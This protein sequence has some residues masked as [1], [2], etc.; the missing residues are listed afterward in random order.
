V[1][2]RGESGASAGELRSFLRERLPDYMTPSAFVLVDEFPQTPN[3][4]I[5]HKALPAPE[6][7]R[8]EAAAPFLAPGTPMEQKVAAIWREVLRLD[9]VGVDDNFFDLGGHSL[10]AVSV[11]ERIRKEIKPELPL[12]K[13][14]QYP[15]VRTLAE[16][17]GA[18]REAPAFTRDSTQDWADRRKQAFRR[19]RQIRS[20]L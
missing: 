4:K 2:T 9:Q 6:R 16:F 17:L 5:D 14:F 20:Q 1:R 12:L 7:S 15:T 3:G 10:L 18:E 19:Q 11:H 13:L 8:K